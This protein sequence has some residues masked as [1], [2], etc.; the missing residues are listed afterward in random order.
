MGLPQP[1]DGQGPCFFG[2]YPALVTDI[3]DPDNLG[4]VQLRF[5][6]L[7]ATGD[8]DVR[9]WATLCTPYADKDQGLAILPEVGS[10]VVVAFEAGDF[11]RPYVVGSTWN[12]KAPLPHRP[13]KSNNIRMLRT[14]N[15]SRITFDDST[16]ATKISITTKAGHKVVLDSGTQEITITH[17]NGSSIKLN[18][19][20][21]ID[22]TANLSVN[23]KAPMVNVTAPTSTFSNVINCQTLIAS[24]GVVSPSYTPGIG[25]VW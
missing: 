12:G 22:I 2:V 25:N 6:T 1:A 3:E 17:L 9:S 5:P 7:G 23:V 19:A 14:R 20:G 24:V 21:G 13:R 15:D 16:A 10:Q 18:P 11:R 8:R 4:R